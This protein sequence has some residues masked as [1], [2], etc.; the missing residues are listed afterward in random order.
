MRLSQQ[1]FGFPSIFQQLICCKMTVMALCTTL[2][3]VEV[4][5]TLK[6]NNVKGR[7]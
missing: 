4:H 3:S 1:I 7:S 6:R 5:L 2:D